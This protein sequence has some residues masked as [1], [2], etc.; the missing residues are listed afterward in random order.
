MDLVLKSLFG[1]S[2]KLDNAKYGTEQKTRSSIN[3]DQ[4]KEQSDNL[5]QVKYLNRVKIWTR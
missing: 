1:K 2:E 5:D 3:L 4:A